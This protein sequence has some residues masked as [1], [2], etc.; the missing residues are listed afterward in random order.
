MILKIDFLI[1]IGSLGLYGPA[2]HRDVTV[3]FGTYL[4]ITFLFKIN[5][6]GYLVSMFSFDMVLSACGGSL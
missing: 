3:C 4:R 2:S 1:D 5:P 6:K